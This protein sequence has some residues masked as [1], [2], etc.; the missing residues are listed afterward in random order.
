MA[1]EGF[2]FA[3]RM[4]CLRVLLLCA[5]GCVVK[6]KKWIC[7]GFPKGSSTFLDVC[8]TKGSRAIRDEKGMAFAFLVLGMAWGPRDGALLRPGTPGL[9]E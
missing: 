2:I 9:H 1:A 7:V 6:G 4:L 5:Q 3:L 8:I